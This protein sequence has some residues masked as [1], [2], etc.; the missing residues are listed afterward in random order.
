M[1]EIIRVIPSLHVGTEPGRERLTSV[2]AERRKKKSAKYRCLR[3]IRGVKK[4]TRFLDLGWR[5]RNS[6]SEMERN[7][8]FWNNGWTDGTAFQV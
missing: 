7:Q 3:A 4:G 1:V 6:V 5:H 8:D 2:G